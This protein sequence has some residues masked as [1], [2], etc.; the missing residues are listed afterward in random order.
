M[1]NERGS[2]RASASPRKGKPNVAV[3]AR[4]SDAGTVLGVQT[5]DRHSDEI[6]F[7]VTENGILLRDA[8]RYIPYDRIS[9]THSRY[10]DKQ[11]G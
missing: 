1:S 4:A 3:T 7:V 11:D 5:V 2:R 10:Q 6:A 9:R 8:A